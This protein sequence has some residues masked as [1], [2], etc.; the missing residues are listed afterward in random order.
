MTE[1]YLT[2]RDAQVAGAVAT[3]RAKPKGAWREP[4]YTRDTTARGGQSVGAY[5]A[6]LAR[7]ARLAPG[8][9]KRTH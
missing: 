9:V 1:L 4:W 7:L 3:G 5:H 2:G 6:T 8:S